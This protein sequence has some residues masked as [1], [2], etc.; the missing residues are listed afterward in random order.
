VLRCRWSQQLVLP[1]FALFLTSVSCN[2]P[3]LAASSPVP[4]LP[5]CLSAA[6][7]VAFVWPFLRLLV[8]LW[9]CFFV[10]PTSVPASL[11]LPPHISASLYHCC[12]V[13]LPLCISAPLYLCTCLPLWC[14]PWKRTCSGVQGGRVSTLTS[15]SLLPH[16]GDPVRQP[17]ALGATTQPEQELLA[18]LLQE[19]I[20]SLLIIGMLFT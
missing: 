7:L 2:F 9:L 16:A 3:G 4:S 10:L 18:S 12:S 8:S 15:P 5:P 1:M 19:H 13:F 17:Y 6:L 11:P 20:L 14:H